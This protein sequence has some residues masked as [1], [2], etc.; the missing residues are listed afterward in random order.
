MFKNIFSTI[1]GIND[2]PMAVLLFFFLFFVGVV[3]MVV[4]LDKKTVNHLESIPLEDDSY[5]PKPE[6]N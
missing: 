5:L 3:L 6:K 2:F 4:R 1:E